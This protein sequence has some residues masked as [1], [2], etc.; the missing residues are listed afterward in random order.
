MNGQT[1]L[2]VP[3][4]APFPA[5]EDALRDLDDFIPLLWEAMDASIGEAVAFFAD[6]DDID[7]SLFPNLVRYHAKRFF[8]ARH[9]A[10]IEEESSDVPAFEQIGLANNGICVVRHRYA[11]RIRKSDNGL[12]PVPGNSVTLQKFYRQQPL[13]F[14]LVDRPPQVVDTSLL[15]LW[16][17][18]VKHRFAGLQLSCP[19][20]GETTRASVQTYWSVE[21]PNP[22]INS[23]RATA[24]T[25]AE[26]LDEIEALEPKSI[27][28][29]G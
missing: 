20:A 26:D 27:R 2:G 22:L 18:D 4:F 1:P 3:G 10:A 15:V 7:P 29:L 28:R 23:V 9:L 12:I 8:L 14:N 11:L 21:I 6:P 19:R 25:L 5:P 17:I 24:R 16:D 13:P